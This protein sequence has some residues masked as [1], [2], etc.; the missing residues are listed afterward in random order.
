VLTDLILIRGA[1]SSMAQRLGDQETQKA[2]TCMPGAGIDQQTA[3]EVYSAV[4]EL[5]RGSVLLTRVGQKH[6]A[7][8]EIESSDGD[9]PAAAASIPGNPAFELLLT[10]VLA[11]VGGRVAE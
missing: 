4:S 3:R 6:N 10:S 1:L 2:I 11:H 8:A 7:A 5:V 9:G